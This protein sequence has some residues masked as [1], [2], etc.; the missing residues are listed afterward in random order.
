METLTLPVTQNAY[1]TAKLARVAD[2]VP[3]VYYGKG[4][5]NLNFSADYQDF[6]RAYQK[7]GRSTILTLVNEDDK[8]FPVLVHEIQYHPVNDRVI[9]VDVV[10]V[11]MN[12]PI[13]TK[14]PLKFI[15]VSLAVKDLGGVFV[16]NRDFVKVKCLPKDLVHEIEVDISLLVDFS[17][18]LTVVNIVAPAGI[19]ILDAPTVN[20][21]TVAA[22]RDIEAEEAAMKAE[23][24]SLKVAAAA[25]AAAIEAGVDLT[26]EG[27]AVPAEGAAAKAEEPAGKAA[28]AEKE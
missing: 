2:R 25:K 13:T 4:I 18:S 12:K 27:A 28:K 1:P 11:D 6:R 7:G 20:V 23:D 26:A 15:G 22:P 10:A 16:H 17:K 5:K 8:Q 9:H 24:E 19:T 21:A 3:M 14:I